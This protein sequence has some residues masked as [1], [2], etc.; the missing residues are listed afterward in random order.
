M[1]CCSA[2]LFCIQQASL[3]CALQEFQQEA[4]QLLHNFN[5]VQP[6][7]LLFLQKLQCIAI[8]D[9]T[10]HKRTNIMLKQQLPNGV[11]ELRHGDQAQHVMKWL[12][13]RQTVQPQTS[14]L[15]VLVASTELA[16]AFELGQQLPSQ[17]QVFAFLPL[18]RYGLRFIVQV[19]FTCCTLLACMFTKPVKPTLTVV[20]CNQHLLVQEKTSMFHASNNSPKH[21]V[22]CA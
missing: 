20:C 16:M 6:T 18:R 3:V 11:V 22:Y 19:S 8:T 15:D 13:V 7:L 1:A 5:D 4:G 2:V 14:R 10:S 12:V 17:Q 9:H 21:P